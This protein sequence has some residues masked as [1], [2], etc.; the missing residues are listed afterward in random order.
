MDTIAS[1]IPYAGK[2]NEERGFPTDSYYIVTFA[3]GSKRDE[4]DTNWSEFSEVRT[5]EYFGGKKQISVSK[6]PIMHI[7]I[8]HADMHTELDVP[9][10]CEI[11]NAFYTEIGFL[12][13]GRTQAHLNGRCVGLVKNRCVIEERFLNARE[14]R[15]FGMKL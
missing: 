9:A 12:P 1:Q 7:E 11:Y 6:L 15:I 3:D 10:D 8:F 5:V 13:D 14:G 4:R 2:T